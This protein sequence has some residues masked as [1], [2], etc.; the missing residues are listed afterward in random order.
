MCH[1][2]NLV[3]VFLEETI[4][5]KIDQTNRNVII[6]YN[7]LKILK[8]SKTLWGLPRYQRPSVS[9]FLFVGKR[10]HSA[11]GNLPGVPKGFKQLLIR[12]GMGYVDKEGA[13][14]KQ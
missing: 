5:P 8:L 13:V 14:E 9:H 1:H 12:E 4:K 7:I 11:L 6:F 10:L 3:C 2:C